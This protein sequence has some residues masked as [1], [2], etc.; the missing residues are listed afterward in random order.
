MISPLSNP[1]TAGIS[2]STQGRSGVFALRQH[3]PLAAGHGGMIAGR[4]AQG[5]VRNELA[6]AIE[7]DRPQPGDDSDHQRESQ[8]SGLRPH[9]LAVRLPQVGKPLKG[10]GG[11]S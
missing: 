9:A 1:P 4:I 7:G 11:S 2:T 5:I 10:V 3:R 8:Q 6:S